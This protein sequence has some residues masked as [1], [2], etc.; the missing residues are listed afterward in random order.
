MSTAVTREPLVG[1]RRVTAEVL[2]RAIPPGATAWIATRDPNDYLLPNGDFVAGESKSEC[3]EALDAAFPEPAGEFVRVVTA[4]AGSGRWRYDPYGRGHHDEWP[5]HFLVL[6]APGLC[7]DTD[8][9]YV[10]ELVGRHGPVW[11]TVKDA[12]SLRKESDFDASPLVISPLPGG[13]YVLVKASPGRAQA[14]RTTKANRKAKAAAAARRN[15]RVDAM[16]R[17]LGALTHAVYREVA[18]VPGLAAALAEPELAQNNHYRG[19]RDRGDADE[20]FRALLG[21][22]RIHEKFAGR[23]AYRRLPAWAEFRRAYRETAA[24]APALDPASWGCG[25]SDEDERRQFLVAE[26]AARPPR[27]PKEK[28]EDTHDASNQDT[29]AD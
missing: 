13:E 18:G 8:P 20:C 15:D 9:D 27:Q 22:I 5:D 17:A 3:R 4:K 28:G 6:P 12:E 29:A 23:R 2:G 10:T 11:M 1:Y 7:E 16:R 14:R 19:D 21:L 25:W 24:P 26:L